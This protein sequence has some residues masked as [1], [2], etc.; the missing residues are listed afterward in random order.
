MENLVF[1]L[2]ATIP[3]FL[4]MILGLLF[5]NGGLFD[6][7]FVKTMNS[8]VFKVALPVL[9]FRELSTADFLQVWD[10]RFV[11]SCFFATMASIPL[12]V[13]IGC[14]LPDRSSRGEFAQAAY[15]SSAALL[16]IGF[17]TNIYGGAGMAPLMIIGTVPL[18]NVMAVVILAF[19]KPDHHK[20]DGAL[21]KTTLKGIVTNP[22]II[23]VVGGMLWSALSI[24]QPEI[25]SK[26]L[27]YV[28]NL[29]TPMGLMAMGATFDGKQALKKWKPA[30]GCSAMKLVVFC[31]IFIP[32]AVKLGFRDSE[33]VSV[34][35]MTGSP[36]TVSCFV[37]AKNMGYEGTVSSSAVMVTTFL[38]A[39]TLTGWLFLI[40]S[41]GLI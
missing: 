30:L 4:L 21:M 14:L 19:M 22:I 31:M 8:F 37:M 33:L 32:L 5:K 15:R 11:A 36:T 34:L 26:T 35:V 3:I 29:A 38:S 41:M 6:D 17:I 12:S 16:G 27:S 10:G 18:Y 28:A 23:G 2:N 24:P 40:R 9:L 39:F 20:I 7:G 25:L 13:G 1:C